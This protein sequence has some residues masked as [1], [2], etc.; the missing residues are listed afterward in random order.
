MTRPRIRPAV[1]GAL[2][3][4]VLATVWALWS[5]SG[6]EVVPVQLAGS[7]AP[8]SAAE[9]GPARSRAGDA[10][11]VPGQSLE[12][13]TLSPAERDP[14]HPSPTSPSPADT[15]PTVEP[16]PRAA[17]VEQAPPA[18]PPAPTMSH[19]L[20]GRFQ[21]PDGSWLVFLQDGEQV[22]QVVPGVTLSDGWR[23]DAL[24]A[25]QVTLRHPT[26]EQPVVLPLADDNAR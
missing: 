14:F 15:P 11:N 12:R 3:A 22:V 2:A 26:V 16:P 25:H 4:T 21:A 5:P 23:V 19:A 7:G 9:Q 18:A 17:A 10:T 8:H 6:P 1:Q 20:L 13:R 24:S